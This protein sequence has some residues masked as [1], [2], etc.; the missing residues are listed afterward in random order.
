MPVAGSGSNYNE[1]HDTQQQ[2]ITISWYT[3][4]SDSWTIDLLINYTLPIAQTVYY[5]TQVSDSVGLPVSS[6]PHPLPISDQYVWLRFV[7]A[8]RAPPRYPTIQEQMA[9]IG[10]PGSPVV[11]AAQDTQNSIDDLRG[12]MNYMTGVATIL[13]LGLL[14]QSLLLALVLGVLGRRR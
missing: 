1:N 9:W 7:V 3:N 4:A 11:K 13:G 8:S 5:W 12:K 2:I 6:G 10:L 14:G